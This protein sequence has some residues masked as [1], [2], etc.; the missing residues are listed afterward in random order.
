M[1][2]LNYTRVYKMGLE[3]INLKYKPGKEDLVCLF[4]VEPNRCSIKEAANNIA[5]ESSIGTWTDVSFNKDYVHR[6]GAKVFSISK[7]KVK[8][9]YPSELF[10][11]GNAPNI[12]S[13]IAG[14]IF[15]MKAVKNLRLEDIKIPDSILRSFS[16]PRYGISGIREMMKVKSRPFIGTIIKPKLG[17]KTRD[18]AEVAY[19]AWVGG[20]DVVKDDENLAGQKFNDFEERVARSL[21]M[22]N[23]AEEETGEKKAYL[24]N[25]T[26][27]TKEMLKRADLVE[28]LG[29]KFIMVDVVTEGFGALQTLRNESFKLAIHAH[30]AMHAAFT[31]NKKHGISMMVLADL[32][33]LIGMDTLHIG[34]VVGKMEGSLDEV[35]EINE[36]V[37][38]KKVKETKI[39]LEQ[40]WGHIKPVLS[41]SSGGLHPLHFPYL[42][43]NLGKDIVLQCGG[44]I[45]GNI[46][47]TR[48]GAM[49][50]RQAIDAIMENCTLKEYS[51]THLELAST[52]AQWG[53]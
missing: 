33:R 15:G 49:A 19:E 26:A 32:S 2:K 53:K 22:A 18:H 44:G 13:S 6:L 10:E 35:S 37:E 52:L 46:L 47:G 41:V 14:N 7:E 39:R 30:R 34:T 9:A 8:I 1:Y 20:C 45:H 42:I 17:L 40:D 12:L 5:L 21:E 48:R 43:K 11:K 36:E 38:K 27:E 16:G 31:R 23:K 3:F 4:R 24:A 25:V 50:A 28:D 29:G 51:K